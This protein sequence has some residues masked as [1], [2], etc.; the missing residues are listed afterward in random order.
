[1]I[2]V[3][4]G[5]FSNRTAYDTA[6][7]FFDANIFCC[8]LSGGLIDKNIK[9]SLTKLKSKGDIKLHNYF[10]PP[11]KPFVMNLAS[12]D[13]NIVKRT[14][15]HIK[16]A[17]EL[18]SEL[19]TNKY[20]F[21]A[22]FLVDPKVD[23]LGR[24]VKKKLLFD[25]A[26]ALNRFINNVNNL[27]LYAKKLSTI[28]LIE[29]NVLSHNNYKHFGKNPFLMVDEKECEYVMKKTEEN[30]F[31]LVDVAHLKV[32]AHSLGFDKLK[33]LKSVY[34]WIRA[35]HLSDNDGLSDSNE[36]V[37]EDSWF[38]PH[39]PNDLDYYSLEVYGKNPMELVEQVK[40]TQ[41]MLKIDY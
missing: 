2:Y 31:L 29:N 13:P 5:G 1:M 34:P 36:P 17:I 9:D 25:R 19:G 22:G 14:V 10:P 23:E 33:F 27:A 4:T 7:N 18:A 20:S 38:W 37:R 26:E 16:K 15:E 28:L 32:S 30:V 35:C 11:E 21:H 8:E 40:L 39:I 6:C 3:S 41:S 24:R 12:D